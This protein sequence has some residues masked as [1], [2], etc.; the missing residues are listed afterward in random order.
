MAS[1]AGLAMSWDEWHRHDALALADRV[2]STEVAASELCAQ[3]AAA[4]ERVD[5]V[6]EAVLGVFDDVVA[7][8]D[9]SGPSR[10][11]RLYGVPMLLK[12]LGSGLA[13]RTQESGSRLFRD[14]V[15]P[16]TDPLV[17]N[18]LEAGL[19]PIGDA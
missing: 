13:G 17:A 16:A 5:P 11:G 1:T 3:A 15:V 14:Y 6:L 7:D 8:P 10:T 4:I 19:V 9:R 2:R 12:D 18:Y